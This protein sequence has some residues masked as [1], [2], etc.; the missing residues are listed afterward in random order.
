MGY[1]VHSCLVDEF[2][3][4]DVKNHRVRTGEE[5]DADPID[6]PDSKA[7][8]FG[9]T[10]PVGRQRLMAITGCHSPAAAVQHRKHC[11][12]IVFCT[13]EY[14]AI[15]EH[16]GVVPKGPMEARPIKI[17]CHGHNHRSDR[18]GVVG[19]LCWPT[20]SDVRKP[21]LYRTP[22]CPMSHRLSDVPVSSSRDGWTFIGPCYVTGNVWGATQESAGRPVR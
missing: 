15:R 1:A 22:G 4:V 5:V 13:P 8:K 2:P 12:P 21:I 20:R 17:R 10:V 19:L 3:E 9:K 11:I 18:I 16:A 6:G 14:L 7:L